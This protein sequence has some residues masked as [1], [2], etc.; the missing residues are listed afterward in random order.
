MDF[1]KYVLGIVL[2]VGVLFAGA[3]AA[4]SNGVWHRA[5][6]IRPGLFGGDEIVDFTAAPFYKFKYL[7]IGMIYDLDNTS[8]YIN[9]SAESN[10]K[11]LTIENGNVINNCQILSDADYNN[12]QCGIDYDATNMV[13][14]T[15]QWHLT[16]CKY[17]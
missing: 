12:L 17:N 5:E 2:I 15:A 4:D 3:Y 9:P 11:N 6:D 7:F 14:E 16:C 13:Y 10:I 8:Y 1:N